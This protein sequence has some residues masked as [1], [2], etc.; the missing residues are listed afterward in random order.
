MYYL[1]GTQQQGQE[2]ASVPKSTPPR[3]KPAY[4]PPPT[5]SAPAPSPT[6]YKVLMV[7]LM[8]AGLLWVVT[9]Y[10]AN[11]RFPIPNIGQW[12]IAAGFAMMM[13]GFIMTTRWR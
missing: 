13:A 3:K 7:S 2:Q 10:L 6:W 1:I 4:T 11:G 8:V 9:T 12:N 5:K